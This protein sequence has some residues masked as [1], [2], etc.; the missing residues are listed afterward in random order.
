MSRVS[1][2]MCAR[3]L[4]ILTATVIGLG[5]GPM[6]KAWAIPVPPD[7]NSVPN[8]NFPLILSDTGLGTNPRIIIAQIGDDAILRQAFARTTDSADNRDANGDGDTWS[9]SADGELWTYLKRLLPTH[10]WTALK[11]WGNHMYTYEQF[12]YAQHGLIKHRENES[13]MG[14]HATDV[15]G[16]LIPHV[17][18]TRKI[19]GTRDLFGYD[20]DIP[21]AIDTY[22]YNLMQDNEDEDWKTGYEIF[23]IIHPEGIEWSRVDHYIGGAP[24]TPMRKTTTGWSPDPSIVAQAADPVLEGVDPGFV[25]PLPDDPVLFP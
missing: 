5:V 8:F 25:I 9:E 19:V 24:P 22:E 4:L 20:T 12:D 16:T 21:S 10:P 23:R 14:T 6:R 13:L 18:A 11:Y 1:F 7:P 2:N 15:P 17:D 3:R